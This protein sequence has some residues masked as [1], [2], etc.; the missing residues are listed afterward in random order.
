MKK[1]LIMA[2]LLFASTAFASDIKFSD[3][4]FEVGMGV[5]YGG[6]VGLTA[7]ME[8]APKTEAFAGLGFFGAIGYVIGGRYYI[9]DNVRLVAN[10]GTNGYVVRQL[11][12][13]GITETETCEGIN[14][15]AEYVWKSGWSAGLMYIVTSDMDD[16]IE[17]LKAQG[18]IIEKPF[19]SDM[20]IK[21]TF[22]YRF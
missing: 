3:I 12:T 10:Y 13:F 16:K 7:N 6:V 20:K 1:S 15:G 2:G 17:E 14:I 19:L 11:V 5:N 18:Y 8:V 22:G 9:N 21:L 4:K